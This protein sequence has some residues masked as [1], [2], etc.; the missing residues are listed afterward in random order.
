MITG[1]PRAS[2]EGDG[3]LGRDH[4]RGGD[5]G[6]GGEAADPVVPAEQVPQLPI[7]DLDLLGELVDQAKV[8]VDTEAGDRRKPET[9]LAGRGHLWRRDPRPGDGDV[10]G[11]EGEGLAFRRERMRTSA[12]LPRAARRAIADL[13]SGRPLSPVC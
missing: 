4:R 6:D 8:R 2:S 3:P 13:P 5:P 11:H 10:V 7:G 9:R 12:V 1:S